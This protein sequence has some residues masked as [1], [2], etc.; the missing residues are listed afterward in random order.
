M[1]VL[2]INQF[3][4]VIQFRNNAN[5]FQGKGVANGYTLN[6]KGNFSIGQIA[7]NFNAFFSWASVLFD[8]DVSDTP[9]IEGEI[10]GFFGPEIAEVT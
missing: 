7:G 1:A 4:Q 2:I 5:M 6:T 3:T 9:I 8:P 10:K